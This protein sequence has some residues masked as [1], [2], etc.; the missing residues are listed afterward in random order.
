MDSKYAI[1]GVALSLAATSAL[2]AD[3]TPEQPAQREVQAPLSRMLRETDLSPSTARVADVFETEARK[4]AERASPDL[5]DLRTALFQL[6]VANRDP[7]MPFVQEPA[8]HDRYGRIAQRIVEKAGPKVVLA[9]IPSLARTATR[10]EETKDA[11]VEEHATVRTGAWS[12]SLDAQFSGQPLELKI[13]RSLPGGG[14][15]TLEY[16][17][18]FHLSCPLPR[19]HD[20]KYS[21]EATAWYGAGVGIG[22][23]CSSRR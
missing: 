20:S 8:L 7:A 21:C 12:V 23:S 9:L 22:L 19:A 11:W 4:F 3:T 2:A 13:R 14:R 17:G 5:A 15:L 1:F 6:S 10:L 16:D 18:E